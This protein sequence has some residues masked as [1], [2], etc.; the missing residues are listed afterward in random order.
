VF[1]SY[2]Q[3][4]IEAKA[5]LENILSNVGVQADPSGGLFFL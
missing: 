3:R 5:G 2:M 4:E 1:I